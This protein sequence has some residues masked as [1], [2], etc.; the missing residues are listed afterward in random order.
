MK[1][2]I[3]TGMLILASLC[4]GAQNYV[5]NGT[6]FEQASPARTV[7]SK[8]TPTIFTW[9]DNKGNTYPIFLHQY[10]KGEKAGRWT[11]YVVKTSAKTGKE[12]KYYLPDGE[13]IANE[14]RNAK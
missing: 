13:K 9:K 12:Y 7:T 10:T 4:A 5:K 1:K 3:I 14:I 8:D 6:T 2:A 11:A